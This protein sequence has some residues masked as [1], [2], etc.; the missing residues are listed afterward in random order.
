MSLGALARRGAKIRVTVAGAIQRAKKSSE[1]GFVL[2]KE[3][4]L[5]GCPARHETGRNGF[6]A[7]AKTPVL[8]A[9]LSDS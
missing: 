4:T 7:Q 5:G 1:T 8:A 6:V 3:K 2:R 9:E